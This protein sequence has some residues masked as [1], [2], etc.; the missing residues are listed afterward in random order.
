MQNAEKT[1]KN[2]KLVDETPPMRGHPQCSLSMQKKKNPKVKTL[3]A[4][5]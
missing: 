4:M 1:S 3:N 5:P 2:I